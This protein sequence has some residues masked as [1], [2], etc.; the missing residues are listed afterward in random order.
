M[1]CDVGNKRFPDEWCAGKHFGFLSTIFNNNKSTDICVF[2]TLRSNSAYVA[3]PQ[4]RS[5]RESQAFF[6]LTSVRKRFVLV[7]SCSYMYYFY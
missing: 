6:T 5:G 4:T 3:D 1:H 7:L 2:E